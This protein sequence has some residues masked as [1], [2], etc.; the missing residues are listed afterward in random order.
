MVDRK[1]TENTSCRIADGSLLRWPLGPIVGRRGASV[2][3]PPK[4][5]R[6]K[7]IL[8]SLAL[9]LKFTEKLTEPEDTALANDQMNL[10]RISF[11]FL[12]ETF[13]LKEPMLFLC[14]SF[15]QPEGW[16]RS[17]RER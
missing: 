12:Q 16:G 17:P 14:S 7:V 10:R 4:E 1:Q 15:P 2:F 5:T 8:F 9:A 11:P 6:Q 3:S 13:M